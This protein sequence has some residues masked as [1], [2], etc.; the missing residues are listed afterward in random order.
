MTEITDLDKRDRSN[1]YRE[2]ANNV[3]VVEI[4]VDEVRNFVGLEGLPDEIS[5]S[6]DEMQGEVFTDKAIRAYVVIKIIE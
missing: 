6:L 4:S 1:L 5:D 3:R 2:N